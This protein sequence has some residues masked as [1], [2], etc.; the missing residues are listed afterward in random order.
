MYSVLFCCYC[1]LFCICFN[2]RAGGQSQS[3][4][5]TQSDDADITIKTEREDSVDKLK[6]S[7][8]RLGQIHHIVTRPHGIVYPLVLK[9]L[10]FGLLNHNNYYVKN[11]GPVVS[12]GF[13]TNGQWYWTTNEFEFGLN[14]DFDLWEGSILGVDGIGSVLQSC[15]ESYKVGEW[16]LNQV[17]R[18]MAHSDYDW[19]DLNYFAP[20]GA[21]L[22]GNI[23]RETVE[24]LE[25]DITDTKYHNIL[26]WR[27]IN[28]A[29]WVSS[30]VLIIERELRELRVIKQCHAPVP[31]CRSR[32][33]VGLLSIISN[34]PT[35]TS[36]GHSSHSHNCS[37][38]HWEFNIRHMCL[39]S[40]LY[41]LCFYMF[42]I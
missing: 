30:N 39:D 4:Q 20:V 24:A 27:D 37:C 19:H 40:T 29:I 31:R 10:P 14:I 28:N 25:P 8:Y 36:L 16:G 22:I 18:F 13:D 1:L 12:L 2:S 21:I 17:Q 32:G 35:F 3:S 42:V 41:V 23:S 9:G 26:N 38:G 6:L 11:S 34:Y 5:R 15:T 7:R 33:V